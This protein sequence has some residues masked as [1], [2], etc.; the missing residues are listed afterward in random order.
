M[1]QCMGEIKS[2]IFKEQNLLIQ[3][4]R[5]K[6]ELSELTAY[7]HALSQ[8]PDYLRVSAIYSDFSQIQIELSID[9]VHTLAQFIMS[10]APTVNHI[11]NAVLVND[12]L[13][14][15]Y[16]F[17]YSEITQVMPLYDCRVFSTAKEAAYFIG[18]NHS[19]IKSLIDTM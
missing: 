12:S 4:Y 5:G 1:E 8:Y 14:I 19:V 13:L 3:L 7:Y 18:Y 16:T 2:K 17:L 9:E 11:S 10:N 15:A 6:I